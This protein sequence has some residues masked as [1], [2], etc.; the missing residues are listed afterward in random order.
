MCAESGDIR[1][2]AWLS[3]IPPAMNVENTSPP[4]MGTYPPPT[5]RFEVWQLDEDALLADLVSHLVA[6]DV[7]YP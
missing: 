6:S 7:H 3:L 2:K 5:C 4:S 1:L